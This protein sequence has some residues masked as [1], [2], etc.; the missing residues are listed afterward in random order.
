M[1][2]V[3]AI[4]MILASVALEHQLIDQRIFVALVTMALVTSLASVPLMQLLM[5]KTLRI[6]A[7]F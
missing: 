2:A 4:E 1:N 3:R 5:K 6:H 7:Y